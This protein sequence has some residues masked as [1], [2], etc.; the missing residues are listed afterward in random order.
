MNSLEELQAKYDRLVN[1]VRR[2]RGRALHGVSRFRQGR[3]GRARGMRGM[4]VSRRDQGR[5]GCGM[6][7]GS[8][9]RAAGGAGSRLAGWGGMGV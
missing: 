7:A 8:R 6:G 1:Q 3:D 2:M 9:M 5:V 4:L